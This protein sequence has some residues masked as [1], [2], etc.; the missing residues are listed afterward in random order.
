MSDYLLFNLNSTPY[1]VAANAV[2]EI[3]WLPELSVIEEAPSYIIGMINLRG[4]VLP[5]MS[6]EKRFQHRQSPALLTDRIIVLQLDDVFIGILV[7]E[8]HDVVQIAPSDIEPVP[9]YTGH[10]DNTKYFI[11][12]EAKINEKLWLVLDLTTLINAPDLSKTTVAESAVIDLFQNSPADERKKFQQRSKL[13]SQTNDSQ[14][15]VNMEAFAIVKLDEE[16]YA[17]AMDQVREFCLLKQ[18][19]PIPCCPRHIMGNMN[20]RG[21][22]LT[23]VDIRPVLSLSLESTLPEVMVVGAD[24]LWVGIPVS[25]VLDV[26]YINTSEIHLLPASAHEINK[27]YCTG[28]IEYNNQLSSILDIKTLLSNGALEVNEVV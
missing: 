17:I 14:S 9:R 16:F 20:L 11:A 24:E 15:N 25:C 21:D 19:T 1:A 26:I 6:L 23:L 7:S 13:L 28:A 18:F 2:T 4:Q 3:F 5:V 22:I 10:P 12:G 8:T 27:E